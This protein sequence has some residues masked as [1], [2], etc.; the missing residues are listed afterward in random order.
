MAR[1]HNDCPKAG[2]CDRVDK[3]GSPCKSQDKVP[4]FGATHKPEHDKG[5][6]KACKNDAPSPKTEG[7]YKA[8]HKK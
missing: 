5:C 7:R 6:H 4:G 1:T 8:R 3:P 2:K